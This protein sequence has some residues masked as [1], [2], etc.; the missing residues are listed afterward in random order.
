MIL[1]TNGQLIRVANDIS[2][3]VP[4]FFA[5]EFAGAFLATLFW[6]SSIIIVIHILGNASSDY[7]PYYYCMPFHLC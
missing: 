3:T 1:F 2:V 6:V 4:D 7:F 5:L